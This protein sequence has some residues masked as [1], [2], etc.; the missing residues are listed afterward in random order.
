MGKKS[1]DKS[2]SRGK[3]GVRSER[4]TRMPVLRFL[5][6][7]NR[8]RGWYVAV[9]IVVAI[10][11]VLADRGGLLVESSDDLARYDGQTFVVTRVIDGDTLDIGVPDGDERTTRLR[12][13]GID[14][15]EVARRD[16]ARSA[17]PFAQEAT[18]LTRQLAQGQRVRLILEPHKLRGHYGRLLVFVELPDGTLL[19][20]KLL[21]AGLA[22]ADSRWS[23]RHF[24]RFASLE[25]EARDAKRGIWAPKTGKRLELTT[26][27][28]R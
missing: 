14:S 16:P 26:G 23:H 18:D 21:S 11:L 10:L 8:R 6:W 24:T 19:N 22:R 25:R 27:D 15:P 12:F 3:S 1:R 7:R 4:A 17:E 2:K 20:E 28:R 5:A 13:W 9:T